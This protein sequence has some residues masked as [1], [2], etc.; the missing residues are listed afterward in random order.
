VVLTRG[1]KA[2]LTNPGGED[3]EQ[4]PDKGG[5]GSDPSDSSDPG[6]YAGSPRTFG[7]VALICALVSV[8]ALGAAAVVLIANSDRATMVPPASAAPP[9]GSPEQLAAYRTRA[10][11]ACDAAIRVD[12][13]F[14][15]TTSGQLSAVLKLS[16]DVSVRPLHEQLARLPP[17]P[18]LRAHHDTMVAAGGEQIRVVEELIAELE[19]GGDAESAAMATA[20][21]L[22]RLQVRSNRAFARLGARRCISPAGSPS[23]QEAT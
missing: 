10:N 21:R 19:S 17:P 7:I 22:D 9:Q 23:A 3:Y 16:L 18:T 11:R 12:E 14:E 8:V 5:I 13:L 6:G 15:P 1:T 2:K 4:S 20:R